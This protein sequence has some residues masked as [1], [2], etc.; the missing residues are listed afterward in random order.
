M[1][2]KD[3]YTKNIFRTGVFLAFLVFTMSSYAFS[4]DD[5]NPLNINKAVIGVLGNQ[6]KYVEPN[7]EIT[8]RIHINN[9]DNDFRATNVTIVDY[10]PDE[11]SFVS[12]N[13]HLELGYYDED[14]RTYRWGY[15]PLE[16][17]DATA[18]N[19]TLRVNPDVRPGTVITNNVTI[20]SDE[21]PESA[22]SVDVI[23]PGV[24]NRFNLS[25]SVVGAVGE[26][27]ST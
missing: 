15:V 26:A 6:I 17:G 2:M 1:I 19:L 11:L 9:N 16:P 8:Y 4:A 27:A 20:Y 21:T 18:I 25:K 24:A 3:K 13:Y 12:A 22:S 14:T 10:L 23:V 7:E 5:A